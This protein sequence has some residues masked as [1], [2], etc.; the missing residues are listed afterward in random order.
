M[1]KTDRWEVGYWNKALVNMELVAWYYAKWPKWEIPN[2]MHVLNTYK[3]KT[4]IYTKKEAPRS[5]VQ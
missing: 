4:D 5:S 1:E 3:Q 2:A